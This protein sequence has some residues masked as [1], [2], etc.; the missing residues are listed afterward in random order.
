[1]PA[2]PASRKLLAQAKSLD[3]LVMLE[4]EVATR[5]SDLASLQA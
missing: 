1:M 2:Y 4:R 3:D 5:E